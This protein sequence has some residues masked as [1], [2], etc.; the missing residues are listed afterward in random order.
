MALTDQQ[1]KEMLS[2]IFDSQKVQVKCGKHLYFAGSK[3]AKPALG[4][5]DCWRVYF[6]NELATTPP[7]ERAQK[8]DELD[9]VIRKMVQMVEAGQWDLNLYK[10]PKIEFG[11]E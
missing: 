3:D 2:E 7:N 1:K 4:C 9:E 5:S 8:L 10:H 11:T 6:I